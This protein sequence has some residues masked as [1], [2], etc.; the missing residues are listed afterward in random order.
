[1]GQL[2][3]LGNKGH[4]KVKVLGQLNH[5]GNKVIGT[6]KSLVQ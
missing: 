2:S 3:S 1:M 5:W 6:V 4:G